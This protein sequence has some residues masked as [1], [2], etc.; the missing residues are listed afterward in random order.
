MPNS[1][2][3][4]AAQV[5]QLPSALEDPEIARHAAEIRRLGRRIADDLIEIGRHL[6]EVKKKLRGRY[7]DWLD[8]EFA[9]SEDTARRYVRLYELS[10]DLGFRKLRNLLLPASSLFLLA[11][12]TPEQRDEVAERMRRGERMTAAKIGNFLA[13]ELAT[14]ALHRNG[15]TKGAPSLGVTPATRVSDASAPLLSPPAPAKSAAVVAPPPA[16]EVLKGP[17]AGMP[18]LRDA[19]AFTEATGTT[20]EPK[21][22]AVFAPTAPADIGP[23]SAA[24]IARQLARLDE[25]EDKVR[26]FEIRELG[27]ADEVKGLKAEVT[28]LKLD[29]DLP[30]NK[31]ILWCRKSL[32]LLNHP[33][34]NVGEVREL[35]TKIL[36]L[37]EPATKGA[38]ISIAPDK[39]DTAA[40]GRALDLPANG[41]GAP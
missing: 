40:L 7:L 18:P 24:A 36:H 13:A 38:K 41:G 33:A 27:W 6:T 8:R 3:A 20:G 28:R 15:L 25:L 2:P 34:Q 32:G 11:R 1:P 39:L 16:A 22:A 35:L 9:W 30:V 5:V 21:T 29:A 26:Q 4:P 14:L 23:H 19:V 10:Q 31:I 12:V 37:V 17:S